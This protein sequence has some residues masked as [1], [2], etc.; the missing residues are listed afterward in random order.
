M[1]QKLPRASTR[2]LARVRHFRA[3]RE[4]RPVPV[5]AAADDAFRRGA[6]RELLR[7]TAPHCRGSR[8]ARSPPR[9][10]RQGPNETRRRP[11]ALSLAAKLAARRKGIT[12]G[13][14]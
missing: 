9:R 4:D 6:A 10:A 12:H 13:G 5:A 11:D 8:V 14:T 1:A 3:A 7:A 2:Q